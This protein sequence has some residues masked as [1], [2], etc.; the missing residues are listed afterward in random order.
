MNDLVVLVPDKNIEATIQGILGRQKSLQIRQINAKILVHPGRDSGCL[1]EGHDLLRLFTRM[2]DHGLILFDREG[3]GRESETRERLEILVEGGLRKSG[4]GDR[5]RA[6]VL[7]PELEIWLWSDSPH[8]PT[9]LGWTGDA[10]SLRDWLTEHQFSVQDQWKPSRPKEAMEKVLRAKRKR[11][12][13]SI[14]LELART[15]GLER[16][17]DPAFLKLKTTLKAWFPA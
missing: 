10:A 2:Y 1:L 9:A 15:V 5:A 6:I 7:D 17:Q 3:S 11:R 14:Y 4:W 12:S 13:S 16:C 8:V